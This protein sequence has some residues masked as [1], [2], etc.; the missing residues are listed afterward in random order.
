[1]WFF[2][3]FVSICLKLFTLKKTMFL[4]DKLVY[5]LKLKETPENPVLFLKWYINNIKY[6]SKYTF[7]RCMCLETSLIIRFFAIKN[8]IPNELKLGTN[9]KDGIFKAHAWIEVNGEVVSEYEDQRSKFIT[10]K[11]K[12]NSIL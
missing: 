4:L 3:N 2:I 8:K 1:M 11:N 12:N 9:I 7:L 6:V 10:F 5:L